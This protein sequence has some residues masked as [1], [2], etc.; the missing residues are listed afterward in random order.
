MM[1]RTHLGILAGLFLMTLFVAGAA[2]EVPVNATPNGTAGAVPTPSAT[3]EVLWQQTYGAGSN[4]T[5]LSL[6]PGREDEPVLVGADPGSG[7]LV[8]VRANGTGVLL[9]QQRVPFG[10]GNTGWPIAVSPIPDGGLVA[11]GSAR[12]VAPGDEDVLLLRLRADG[13]P[14]WS[15]TYAIGTGVDRG[16]AVLPV[17]DGGLL[18]A[19]TTV[20]PTGG[21]TDLLLLRLD[22]A[23]G[24]VWHRIVP[25]GGRNLAVSDLRPATGGG[26]LLVGSTDADR[27]GTSAVLLALITEDGSKAWQRT[28]AS[29]SG[30]ARGVTLVPGSNG[31][32]LLLA[33]VGGPVME[34]S[35]TVLI[36]VD[37]DGRE[38]WRRVPGGDALTPVVGRAL[39][40]VDQRGYL[41]AGEIGGAG[42]SRSLLTMVDREGQVAWNGSWSVGEGTAD[43]AR[44]VLVSGPDRYLLAGETVPAE[45]GRSALYLAAVKVGTLA[46]N[47]T[48]NVTPGTPGTPTETPSPSPLPPPPGTTPVP[49]TTA[50]PAG[51]GPVLGGLVAAACLLASPRRR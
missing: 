51:C 4:L 34:T 24:E 17:A 48:A 20:P 36:G 8:L 1:T 2:A 41:V 11:V 22:P 26:Y 47:A 30:P 32:Y 9:D 13:A 37:T 21:T 31:G 33:V 44:A 18:V 40:A 29:S 5:F 28:Y 6:L 14:V 10:P 39:T 45:G 23:G 12:S 7:D 16:T 35:G 43:R 46:P 25:I 3:V 50:A 42:A 27:P 19:G 38:R 49:T 15:R